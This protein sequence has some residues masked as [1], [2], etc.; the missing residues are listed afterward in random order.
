MIH[1]GTDLDLLKFAHIAGL[2]QSV[3]GFFPGHYLIYIFSISKK[4]SLKEMFQAKDF[5]LFKD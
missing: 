3:Q 1:F 2:T 4:S 5:V